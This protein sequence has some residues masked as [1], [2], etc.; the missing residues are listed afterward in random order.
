M[1]PR[2]LM[3][4]ALDALCVGTKIVSLSANYARI[5]NF[6]ILAA[7]SVLPERSFW[8]IDLAVSRPT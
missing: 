1:S 2:D 4:S 3:A 5:P 7:V 8:I 6:A